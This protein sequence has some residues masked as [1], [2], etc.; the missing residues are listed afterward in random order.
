MHGLHLLV[1]TDSVV[2]AKMFSHV[3]LQ[4]ALSQDDL[5]LLLRILMEN[6][7]EASSIQPDISPDPEIKLANVPTRSC[8]HDGNRYTAS[9]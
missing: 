1:Y 2:S 9:Y 7:G 4:V 6:I 8:T 5:H 3:F